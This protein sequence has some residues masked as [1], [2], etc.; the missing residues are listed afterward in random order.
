MICV[1]S[2]LISASIGVP[3]IAITPESLHVRL[4]NREIITK[5]NIYFGNWKGKRKNI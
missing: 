2:I 1:V 5:A 3:Q 4:E